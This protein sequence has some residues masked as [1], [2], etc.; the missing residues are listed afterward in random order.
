MFNYVH[1]HLISCTK[2]K[3]ES[4]GC[5]STYKKGPDLTGVWRKLE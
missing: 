2:A 4:T 5:L 3:K 1:Y